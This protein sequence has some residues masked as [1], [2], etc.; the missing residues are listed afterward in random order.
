MDKGSHDTDFKVGKSFKCSKKL[1]SGKHIYLFSLF[2]YLY[3]NIGA[4]GEIY[5]GVNI[6]TNMDVAIKFEPVSTKHP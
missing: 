2:I 6:K 5:K 3:L 1:G 4:F